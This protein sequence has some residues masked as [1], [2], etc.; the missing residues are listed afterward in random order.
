M[1]RQHSTASAVLQ[2]PLVIRVPLRHVLVTEE[3]G[4]PKLLC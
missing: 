4:Q 2:N 3:S 1:S